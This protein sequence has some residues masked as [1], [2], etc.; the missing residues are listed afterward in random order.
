MNDEYRSGG[1]SYQYHYG[2][3]IGYSSAPSNLPINQA[4][5]P[6]GLRMPMLF[7]GKRMRKTIQV[8][9]VFQ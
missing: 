1:E 6:G 9:V 2:G 3:N 4:T 7:D 8:S 5:L